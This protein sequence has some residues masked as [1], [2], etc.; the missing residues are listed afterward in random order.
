MADVFMGGD[1]EA[2]RAFAQ[3]VRT[4]RIALGEVRASVSLGARSEGFWRGEDAEAFRERI[5]SSVLP[6]LDAIEQALAGLAD[7]ADGHA[8]EQ[9]RASDPGDIDG[10]VLLMPPGPGSRPETLPRAGREG[11]R[12]H[13]RRGGD[14]DPG[15][16]QG[17]LGSGLPD[18]LGDPVPGTSVPD[19]GMPEWHPVDPGAGDWGSEEPGLGDLAAHEAA[20]LMAS[21]MSAMWPDAAENLLH[22][23]GNSGT[24]R[25]MDLATYLEDEPG[26]RSQI[27]ERERGIGQLAL[28]RA[29]ESGAQG[30]VTFPVQ[31]GWPGVTASSDNW[32]Y[33]T[34][35]GNYSMNGQVTVY[36]PDATHPEWRYEMETTLNYRDQ[37]NWDGSKATKIDLPGPFDPTITDEQLAELHRAGLAREY[38]LHGTSERRTSGP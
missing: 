32:Y 10:A 6:E 18:G 11:G 31:T 35:S 24:D 25:E 19:P 2:L 15:P 12:E 23:L 22:F 7:D 34:G 30:P 20:T 33:A 4:G 21:L 8:E 38:Q 13:G 16:S 27:A 29:R 9:D 37:Y 26:I 28:D 14:S 36:P 3:A 5:L 17:P 1:T